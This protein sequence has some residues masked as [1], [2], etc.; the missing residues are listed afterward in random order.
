[1]I[2]LKFPTNRT[3]NSV[4]GHIYPNFAIFFNILSVWKPL[5]LKICNFEILTIKSVKM[6]YFGG[7]CTFWPK[8]RFFS[9]F[10]QIILKIAYLAIF[11]LILRYFL[12]FYRFG[13]FKIENLQLWN[14]D[15]TKVSKWLILA[16][17]ALFGPKHDFSIISTKSYSK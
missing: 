14:F 12:I 7:F 11:I 5:K 15:H 10:R 4:S 13:A 1:M 3:Q 17:F 9:N 16:V 6:G 8:T 2:I